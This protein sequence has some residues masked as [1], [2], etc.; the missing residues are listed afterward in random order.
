MATTWSSPAPTGATPPARCARPWPMPA[1]NRMPWTT[2]TRTPA[3]RPWETSP[4]RGPWKRRSATARRPCPCPRTKALTGHP[5]GAT[6]AIEAALAALVIRDGWAPP[7]VN[8]ERPDPEIEARLGG[9]IRDPAGR[10][11]TYD[12]VLSTSFGFG[13]L[14]AALV[15]GAAT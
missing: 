4:R 6:A 12:R 3:P 8:L 7:S 2:S 14:N 5:L 13:G 9:L 11:G 1:T 15:F 10:A